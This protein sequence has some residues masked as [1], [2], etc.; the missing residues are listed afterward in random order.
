M[1]G[2]VLDK[3]CARCLLRDFPDGSVVKIPHFQRASNA[4]GMGL[5]PG[6]GTKN[7]HAVRH[8]QKKRGAFGNMQACF[9][10]KNEVD[11]QTWSLRDLG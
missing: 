10:V 3:L 11:E 1:A 5:I 8:S 2:S 4:G 7:P 6:R 9:L